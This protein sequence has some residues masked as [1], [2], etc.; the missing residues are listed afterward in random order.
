MG[1]ITEDS[2][3]GVYRLSNPVRP[4]IFMISRNQ[5]E[6]DTFYRR[7]GLRS[8]EGDYVDGFLSACVRIKGGV[9]S[10]T[11]DV[12]LLHLLSQTLFRIDY[13]KEKSRGEV[14]LYDFQGREIDLSN[15]LGFNP[16]FETEEVYLDGRDVLRIAE[17]QGIRFEQNTTLALLR[18]ERE[19]AA[20]LERRELS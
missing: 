4:E 14:K 18:Q 5:T 13:L 16:T 17:E 19:L 1:V 6:G 12:A 15:L 9:V 20:C 8:S 11:S 10:S 3:I 7:F 2:R